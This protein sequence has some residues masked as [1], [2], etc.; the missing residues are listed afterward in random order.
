MINHTAPNHLSTPR[1]PR[2]RT[3]IRATFAGALIAAAAL[4]PLTA[5]S[6][7]QPQAHAGGSIGCRT[8]ASWAGQD[9]YNRGGGWSGYYIAWAVA[10][11]NCVG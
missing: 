11:G 9:A 2:S 10:Y 5:A 6:A 1:T 3:C 7:Q 8:L 4:L